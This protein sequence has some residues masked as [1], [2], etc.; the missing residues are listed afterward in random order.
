MRNIG[1]VRGRAAIAALQS[2]AITDMGRDALGNIEIIDNS[3]ILPHRDAQIVQIV[4][5]DRAAL[6]GFASR[7]SGA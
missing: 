6:L 2:D 3:V 4:R 5:I 7:Y 1:A